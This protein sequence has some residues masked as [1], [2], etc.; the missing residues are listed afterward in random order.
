MFSGCPSVSARA[1]V[2]AL[3]LLVLH[4]YLTN[5]RTEFHQSLVDGVVEGI[6]KLFVF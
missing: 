6:D 3:L 5:Q 2:R 4:V 1:C